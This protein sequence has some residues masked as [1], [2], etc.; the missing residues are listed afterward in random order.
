M[1]K[2][3]RP[4]RQLWLFTTATALVGCGS[5]APDDERYDRLD[6][7]RVLA[8]QSEPADI[9]FGETSTLSANVYEPSDRDVKYEWSWCPSRSDGSGGFECNISEDALAEAWASLGLGDTPPS[10]DLGSNPEA[11]FTHVLTP[12]LVAALCQSITGESDLNE[13]IALAC[14]MG[15][16]ASVKLTV[17]TSKDEVTAIRTL[18]LLMGETPD[19]SERNANPP[20]NFSVTLRDKETSAVVEDGQALKAGHAYTVTAELDEEVAQTFTP[21]AS[22]D[23]PEPEERRE[24]LIMSWFLTEGGVVPPL[25]DPGLGEGDVRSTFVDGTNDFENVTRNGWELPLTAGPS[26][27]LHLV[28]RDE[29]GGVGWTRQSFEVTGGEK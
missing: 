26:A 17:R 7:L 10:Y 16:R 5:F 9:A 6:K 14:F 2:L 23:D 8:I 29:R 22:P 3:T 1:R 21:A 13:E 12:Q 20:S 18:T 19:A 24:T 25:D 4:P 27:E 15:L 11:Q 28:L